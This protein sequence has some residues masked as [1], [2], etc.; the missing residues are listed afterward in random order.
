[1]DI[2]KII[3]R[4][5]Y[6]W[7]FSLT[8]LFLEIVFRLA[9]VGN[10]FSMGLIYT[11]LFS[12]AYGMIGFLLS[13][14][15]KDKRV[16]R[17]I[18]LVLLGGTCLA[19]IVQFLIY[20]QF[21]QFYDIN[22]MTNGAGDALTSYYKELLDLIFPQGGIFIIL[23]MCVPFVLAYFFGKKWIG[24]RS[25]NAHLRIWSVAVAVLLYVLSFLLIVIHPI[26]RPVY[27]DE[28]NFQAAVSH[29]GLVTGLRLD[30]KNS[31][32]ED[33]FE[34]DNP[35]MPAIPDV[36]DE[37]G[38]Q[39]ATGESTEAT[40]PEIVYGENIINIDFDKLNKKASSAEKKLND[41]VS[42]LTA[43]KKNE[44]TGLFKGKNL[45]MISA[46]A[47]SAEVISEELTPTLYRMANKGI[48][49]TDYYQPASAGTTGGEYQ[50]LFGMLPMD[51]GKSFK[52]TADHLNYYT[53]GS[54][55]NRLGYYGKAFHNNSYKY[56]SRHLTHVNIGYSDGYMG[57]GNGMEE[58]VKKA[59]PQSDLQMIAGT[60]PTYIDKQPFN[61]YYMSVSGH[62]G[63][64][65][66]GNSQ[67]KK[68]WDKVA[69]LPYSDPVKGY[70]AA[71]LELE[72]AM[73]HLV[74]ELE[75]KGIADDTVIC[76]STDHFPYGLDSD[77]KLGNMPYLSEL[78][79]YEVNDYF[80]RD[81]SRLILW[82][83]CLEKMEPIV[84]DTPTFSLD[85]LP[86]LSNLFGTE[87]DSRLMPGRDVFSD[88][89]AL[90]FNTNYDWK[91]EYGTYYSSKGKFVPANENIQLPENYVANMK[92]IVK[93]KIK[94]CDG[95][96]ETD[97]Y[98]H[99]FG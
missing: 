1:M 36:E 51:G 24:Y 94:Y 83:G 63:Y 40:E 47:F 37:T 41:Y 45:I 57:Y 30:I 86:T 49:F 42:T 92:K 77:A 70:I 29:F 84:V 91:T 64:S 4:T 21:K 60:L 81:H 90:V 73:A 31:T 14:V 43:S 61:I 9:T 13:T 17:V 82:S 89:P 12:I 59:W 33:E 52:N 26:Y 10:L 74:A 93:N 48:Q 23:L 66:S 99:I 19:Y 35:E 78:Y 65:K 96:L 18:S 97:Y 2:K 69:N 38:A 54:Q 5:L 53:M 8:V 11:A 16:N 34:F 7:Y 27:G 79:G 50:N 58:Y 46:E 6:L 68:H 25:A 85:I 88:A 44:M 32:S 71:N 22:T 28:Y 15:F 98:R 76:I 20:K 87:F 62:S 56:Y 67:T 3:R 75:A 55:L 95:V 39:D 80:Q 72:A